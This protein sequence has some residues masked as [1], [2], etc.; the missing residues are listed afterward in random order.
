M[1]GG[2][3][4]DRLDSL[5]QEYLG[6][7]VA[8]SGRAADRVIEEALGQTVKPQEIYLDI[9]Q[10]TAY[11]IGQLW[12][13]NKVSVAQEHL[14]TAIIERQMGELHPMFKPDQAGERTLVI[15]CVPD[16]W[17]RV[18]ARMVADFF[19]ADGWTVHY[20]GANVPIRDIVGMA[21]EVSA[22]LI[23]LSSEMLFNLPRVSELVRALDTA[24]LD[25]IP[26]IAGGMP[27]VTQPELWSSLDLHGCAA[28]AAAA[29]ALADSI[30]ERE[31]ARLHPSPEDAA[32]T[33][34][35]R[36]RRRLVDEATVRMVGVGAPDADLIEPGFTLTIRMVEAALAAGTPT[37][38][39]EQ[40]NW[41]YEHQPYEG[42][43][44]ARTLVGLEHLAAT[45][46]DLIP[47][48][49]GEVAGLYF[50]H[51]IARMQQL[52]RMGSE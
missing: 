3:G 37:L 12:Q 10:P 18:G 15:G 49:E 44:A 52:Q 24:G 40:V 19:E 36:M 16:E 7:V 41:A 51:L 45:T 23:G 25:G 28:D 50:D 33:V 32:A 14:A 39:D 30:V 8:G 27:F 34:L 38:L 5:R 22:D 48:P 6:A 43:S 4:T 47:P 21:R 26:V 13:A 31:S 17:H 1:D 20:L 11:T 29:V 2:T 35:R 46:R 42:V 9:F